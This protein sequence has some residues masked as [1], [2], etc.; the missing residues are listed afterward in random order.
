MVRKLKTQYAKKR[1]LL[2]SNKSLFYLPNLVRSLIRT[3]VYVNNGDNV[4]VTFMS[5]NKRTQ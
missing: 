5:Y 4:R 1:N 2:K 3:E